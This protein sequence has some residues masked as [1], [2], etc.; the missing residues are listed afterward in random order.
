MAQVRI[1]I[2]DRTIV[3]SS[4]ASSLTSMLV[5]ARKLVRQYQQ[6]IPTLINQIKKLRDVQQRAKGN[7]FLQVIASFR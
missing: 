6:T 4:S 5:A 2:G 3:Y 7:N 1:Q